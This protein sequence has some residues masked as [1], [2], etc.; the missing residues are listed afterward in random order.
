MTKEEYKE[1]YMSLSDMKGIGRELII[2]N[3]T[4]NFHKNYFIC[5]NSQANFNMYRLVF[6]DK[7]KI[8]IRINFKHKKC[9]NSIYL[10]EKL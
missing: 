6:K 4:M 10:I 1:N 9:Y 7:N 2:L 3:N 5:Q 8:M